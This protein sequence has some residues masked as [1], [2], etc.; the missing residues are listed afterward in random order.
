MAGNTGPPANFGQE[1][2]KKKKLSMGTLTG[3][4]GGL[5]EVGAHFIP[6]TKCSLINRK[7]AAE[8]V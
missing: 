2:K 8:G 5:V 4:G 1:L 6:H 3:E 7:P